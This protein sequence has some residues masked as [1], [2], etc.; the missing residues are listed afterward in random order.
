MYVDWTFIQLIRTRRQ[1]SLL[2]QTIKP[3]Q[4]LTAIKSVLSLN[5][6]KLFIHCKSLRFSGSAEFAGCVCDMSGDISPA[7]RK[8]VAGTSQRCKSQPRDID[9][10]HWLRFWK[11]CGV[12]WWCTVEGTNLLKTCFVWQGYPD[13][14]D[15]LETWN[16]GFCFWLPP[17]CITSKFDWT[18]VSHDYRNR[19]YNTPSSVTAG[20][21][22]TT[23]SSMDFFVLFFC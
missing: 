7:G 5:H 19:M 17:S 3:L 2:Q 1:N 18:L 9:P 20:L 16:Q 4:H 6:M 21:T 14:I 13:E 15:T 23:P 22:P 10:K 11:H 12:G 8:H